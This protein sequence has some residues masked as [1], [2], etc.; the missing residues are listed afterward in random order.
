MN[1]KLPSTSR[2]LPI[3]LIRAREGAMA[4]IRDMLANTGI[5][6]QQWRILRVL[7]E[8]GS[9]D[10]TTLAD[11]ASLLF[12]SLTRIAAKMRE[13]G[14]ITQTRDEADRRRQLIEITAK[15]QKFIDDHAER[16]ALVVVG[17][18]TRLGDDNYEKLLDLL[19]L[20]DPGPR[21]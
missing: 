11:R 3:A 12:P 6:E 17:F 9:L 16:A 4:P 1:K 18:R 15:G 19:A 7:S 13:K 2:S 8:H 14:L 20:L 10:S 21:D 5:T